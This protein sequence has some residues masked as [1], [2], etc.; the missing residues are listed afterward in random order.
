M[1]TSPEIVDTRGQLPDFWD[2]S[3]A[4][5]ANLLALFYG[6]EGQTD[7]L[8][9]EVG[10]IESYGGRLL[11]IIDLLF[12][13]KDNLLVLESPPNRA[14]CDYFQ[15]TLGLSLPK[16]ST[17]GH[18]D[19]AK[20]GKALRNG[21]DPHLAEFLGRFP[22][23]LP[24]W[25]DGFV[26]DDTLDAL[27]RKLDLRTI[28]SPGGSIRGNNKWL[29]QQF[30]E[31][32]DLPAF[33][34]EVAESPE[35]V[36]ACLKALAD[37]GYAKAA[38]K[39]QIGAS[40]IGLVKLSTRESG[41][42]AVPECLFFEGPVMIQ[43]WLE[44]GINRVRHLRS[45]SVQLFLN[46]ETVFLYDVTEQILSQDSIHEGN[47]SPPAYLDSTPWLRGELYRYA[48]IAGTWLHGQ[49]YR[50]T[51][52]VDFLLVDREGEPEP[53]IIICEINARVTGATYPAVLARQFMPHGSWLMRNL[54]FEPPTQAETLLETL[55]HAG[56]LFAPGEPSGI[57]P[58]NF[59]P[60][61]SSGKIR[62]GQFLCLAEVPEQC[63]PLLYRTRETL[64]VEW[65]Y[66]RD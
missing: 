1:A 21:D 56:L 18:A 26:T 11:P 10:G 38:A 41:A 49:D 8:A 42:S 44:P 19:Y 37:R 43:G 29:L 65:I 20:L 57:L 46:D 12:R 28:C 33:D 16:L 30:L 32:E 35:D 60:D 17:L 54:E 14:L 53:E 58:I 45:P 47:E 2:R 40:G 27:A 62:K 23:P 25:L 9:K 34:T 48:G 36:P 55:E 7:L 24:P 13:G 5:F 15:G 31:A 6:N 50:G 63:H 61:S 22:D 64:P 4:F 52:S 59:N 3:A 66:S 39:S 51:A